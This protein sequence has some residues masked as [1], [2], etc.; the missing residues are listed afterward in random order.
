MS[1]AQTTNGRCQPRTGV[2]KDVMKGS[3]Q[4]DEQPSS[5]AGSVHIARS[6]M[7]KS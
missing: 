5:R 2:S 6:R 1:A 4:G 3:D 7:T